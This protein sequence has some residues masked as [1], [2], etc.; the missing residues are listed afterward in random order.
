[1]TVLLL[2]ATVTVMEFANALPP[3]TGVLLVEHDM[4]ISYQ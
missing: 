3:G 2:P 1:M 4:D